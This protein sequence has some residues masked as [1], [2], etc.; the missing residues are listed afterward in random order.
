MDELNVTTAFLC[1]VPLANL[2]LRVTLR[3]VDGCISG[4]SSS[5]PAGHASGQQV[6]SHNVPATVLVQMPLHS[7]SRMPDRPF[8]AVQ[9]ICVTR[10]VDWQE[11]LEPAGNGPLQVQLWSE[12]DT[13][14]SVNRRPDMLFHRLHAFLICRVRRTLQGL[15]KA[16]ADGP[17]ADGPAHSRVACHTCPTRSDRSV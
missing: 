6:C 10:A 12:H 8:H 5:A 9:E 7:I 15:D 2:R 13:Q 4:V 14:V 11:K 17:V 3:R 1:S 16:V